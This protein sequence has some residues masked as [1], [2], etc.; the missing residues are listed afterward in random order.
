MSVPDASTDAAHTSEQQQCLVCGDT[1]P[2]AQTA[3]GTGVDQQGMYSQQ[4]EQQ[5]EAVQELVP[6][7]EQL[8]QDPGQQW[9]SELCDAKFS[10][11][12]HQ[13]QPSAPGNAQERVV[14]AS[15]QGTV[16]QQDLQRQQR[17]QQ[18]QQQQP[19][20]QYQG[21]LRAA[22]LAC[23]I[24]LPLDAVTSASD[25][26]GRSRH[27]AFGRRS[28]AQSTDPRTAAAAAAAAAA[29]GAGACSVTRE[30]EGVFLS[31]AEVDEYLQ[32][33]KARLLAR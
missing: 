14:P 22:A 25:S 20:L 3:E 15:T 23:G 26:S 31:D 16:Q 9:Q 27:I 21:S 11:L 32:V 30:V 6:Q 5:R 8:L 10:L 7:A 13:H 12:E 33:E 1:E 18:Q 29:G 17:Q 28:A 2:E 24:D 19:R 4:L